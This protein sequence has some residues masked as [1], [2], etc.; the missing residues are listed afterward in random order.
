MSQCVLVT[1]A[2]G[3]VGKQVCHYF[4]NHGFKVIGCGRQ[5]EIELCHKNF[6][7]YSFDLK[8][9]KLH[10][11]LLEQVD[12]VIHLAALAHQSL[13]T[14]AVAFYQINTEYTKELVTLCAQYKVK[15]FIFLSSIKV[16]GE[17]TSDMPFNEQQIPK[18]SDEYGR[19]KWFAE[20]HVQEIAN[21]AGMAWVIIRPPLVYGQAVK[22]NFASLIKL[23]DK[24][25]PIPFGKLCNQRSF[26]AIDNLC[27]FIFV[28]AT[29][30][31]A[32]HQL[33]CISDGDDQSTGT[34]V[35]AL[36]LARTGQ[37]KLFDFPVIL[38]KLLCSIAGK[39]N[40][41]LRLSESLQVDITKAK[42]LLNWQP[43]LKF[44]EAVRSYFQKEKA[45]SQESPFNV[46][47]SAK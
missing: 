12:C 47:K 18:P 5:P 40:V 8:E 19:S 36:Q 2:S 22:A 46:K 16:N 34:L 15:R 25:I 23:V 39:Q 17:K 11:F 7:Y 13:N 9:L 21:E 30:S 3:F 27:D 26:I 29:N 6:Q 45:V 44:E 43:K 37:I 14:P 42:Q 20:H 28:C 33:F 31:K 10:A 24:N 41:F 1:G 32:D 35:K 4:L 38:L